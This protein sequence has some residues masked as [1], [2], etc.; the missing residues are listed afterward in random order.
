M[1]NVL[2]QKQL[3]SLAAEYFETQDR[4]KRIVAARYVTTCNEHAKSPRDM[5]FLQFVEW[6]LNG[7]QNSG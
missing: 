6:K 1:E 5:G 3:R 2:D 7:I 4:D